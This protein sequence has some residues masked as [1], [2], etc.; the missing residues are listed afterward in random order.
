MTV[1]AG[2]IPVFYDTTTFISY[3]FVAEN[4]AGVVC[5]KSYP[6]KI[7]P[8]YTEAFILE[9]LTSFTSGI[10]EYGK[11][12]DI[13]CTHY[14]KLFSNY[15]TIQYSLPDK[16]HVE[17][18]LHDI[19]GRTVNTLTNYTQMKGNYSYRWYGNDH[20]GQLLS[21]GIYFYQLKV[22]NNVYTDRVIL[23]R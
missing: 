19:S 20:S 17:L 11:L 5:V 7:N 10:E 6:D 23:I 3:S 22:G 18:T 15:T 8:N 12:T 16:D 2:S 4:Y 14:P 13:E 1:Y 21:S 9:R